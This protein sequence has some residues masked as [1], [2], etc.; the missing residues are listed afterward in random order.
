MD[1]D[2]IAGSAREATETLRDG[3]RDVAKK[4]GEYTLGALLVAGGVGF[5]LA[6]LMGGPPR[7]QPQHWRDYLERGRDYWDR[8]RDR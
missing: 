7:R 6:V 8:D 3:S 4:V 2:R 1:N 5:A